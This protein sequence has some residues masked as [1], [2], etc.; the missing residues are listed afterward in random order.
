MSTNPITQ[1]AIDALENLKGIDIRVTPVQTL[2][3]V[4]DDMI[5]C[6][7]RSSRHVKALANEVVTEAKK[8]GYLVLSTTG[9]G[10]TEWMLVDLGDAVV[11]IMTASAR[12]FYDLESLWTQPRTDDH[13]D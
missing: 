9:T 6:T 5:V 8:H 3:D 10:Q 2:T 7:G 12:A 1:C 4:M 11:H 13:A